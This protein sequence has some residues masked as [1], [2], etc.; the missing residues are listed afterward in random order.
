MRHHDRQNISILI[1]V[2]VDRFPKAAWTGTLSLLFT[3]QSN[4]GLMSRVSS[5]PHQGIDSPASPFSPAPTNVRSTPFEWG[6]PRAPAGASSQRNAGVLT[7]E[8]A[9]GAAPWHGA[10]GSRYASSSVEASRVV[11][12]GTSP[13][14]RISTASGRSLGSIPGSAPQC[15]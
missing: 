6:S 3:L 9:S 2:C 12:E 7:S 4:S 14:A 8:A 13:R 11:S 15:S 10:D 1:G 5:F